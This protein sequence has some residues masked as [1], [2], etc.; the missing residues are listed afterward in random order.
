L[1]ND[2]G[3]S[4]VFSREDSSKGVV[5]RSSTKWDGTPAVDHSET[6][7]PTE[8]KS[9]KHA[10]SRGLLEFKGLVMSV[11]LDAAGMPWL[12]VRRL[13]DAREARSEG[14]ALC[15]GFDYEYELVVSQLS[16]LR[17][18]P[19][20]SVT[21]KFFLAIETKYNF[22]AK[23]KSGELPSENIYFVRLE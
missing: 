12:A 9:M 16:P 4:V 22:K 23:V 7:A 10:K 2:K 8:T 3:G 1:I 6:K 13:L 19:V 5:I 18:F 20:M 14:V 15:E 17:W 11:M 21:N